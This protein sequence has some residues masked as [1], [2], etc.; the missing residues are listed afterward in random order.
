MFLTM[1]YVGRN[2]SKVESQGTTIAGRV[3]FA[4][5]SGFSRISWTGIMPSAIGSDEGISLVGPPAF[6]PIWANPMV[7]FEDRFDHRPGS[8]DG[9]FTRE[10]RTISDHG[11]AQIAARTAFPLPAV[12]RTRI[13]LAGRR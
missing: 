13:A 7:I 2:S 9:V 10:E 1:G 11:V 8:L 6:A 3:T 4:P 12:P 5:S